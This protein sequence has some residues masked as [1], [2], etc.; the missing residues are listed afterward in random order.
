MNAPRFYHGTSAE[1]KRGDL[2][3]PNRELGI[4]R[5]GQALYVYMTTSLEAARNYGTYKASADYYRG[6]V[7]ATGH[8]YQVE[9]TGPVEID[10]T[11]DPRFAAYRSRHPLRVIREV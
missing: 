11:V 6:E 2:V 5:R 4:R 7:N 10:D 9:P 1:L 8:V 3:D